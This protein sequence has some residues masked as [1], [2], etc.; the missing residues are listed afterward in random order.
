MNNDDRM[1]GDLL[2]RREAVAVLAGTGAA[3]LLAGCAPATLDRLASATPGPILVPP[4]GDA[5]D[6]ES[7]CALLCRAARPDRGTLLC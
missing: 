2:S 6:L 4:T 1:V 3:A 5:R 7:G